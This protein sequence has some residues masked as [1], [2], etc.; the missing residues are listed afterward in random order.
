MGCWPKENGDDEELAVTVG[1][2]PPLEGVEVEVEGFN[3]PKPEVGTEG[4]LGIE[5]AAVG[6]ASFLLSC[7]GLH[8]DF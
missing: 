3:N 4:G 8:P 1:T 5:R 7:P 2:K 6:F